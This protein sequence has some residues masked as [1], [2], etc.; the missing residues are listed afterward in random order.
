M[1]T[2]L[3]ALQIVAWMA[4]FAAL[5]RGLTALR[6]Q[7]PYYAVHTLHNAAVTA[8]TLTDVTT[9]FTRFYEVQTLP[10]NWQ[11]VYLVY[12]LH[13]YHTA[14]YWRTFR[15]DDWLHHGLMIGVALPLGGLVPAGP[16]MGFSLFF[17]T[18]LPGGISY[19][20]LWAER[21]GWLSRSAEKRISQAVNVWIRA[22]GCVAHGALTLAMTLASPQG[23]WTALQW[24]G[25]LEAALTTWNGLY[26]MEQVVAASTLSRKESVAPAH[27]N[28]RDP[29]ANPRP[30]PALPPAQ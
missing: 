16:L 11:A 7:R 5:D 30:T 4:L 21:N 25:L 15:F 3:S 23:A 26:F 19:G 28:N 14:L 20:A 27:A 18:G 6:L 10:I 1:D 24:I 12:A 22:P 2:L 9:S 29:E 13:F 8:L 17:T